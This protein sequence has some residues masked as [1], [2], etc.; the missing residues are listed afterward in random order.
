MHLLV[1]LVAVADGSASPSSLLVCRV[2]Q[3]VDKSIKR[4]SCGFQGSRL[5]PERKYDESAC[6]PNLGALGLARQ[7]TQSELQARIAMSQAMGALE[8]KP[9]SA[10]GGGGGAGRAGGGSGSGL[11]AAT[12][13]EQLLANNTSSHKCGDLGNSSGGAS[14]SSTWGSHAR[15]ARARGGGDNCCTPLLLGLLHGASAPDAAAPVSHGLLGDGGGGAAPGMLLSSHACGGGE[16]GGGGGVL[17]RGIRGVDAGVA[18]VGQLYLPRTH[19]A[20]SAPGVSML[21]EILQVQVRSIVKLSIK[22]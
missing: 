22:N 9:Y 17:A 5:P 12:V 1:A 7:Q 21:Q 3:G 11:S 19:L 20:L 4:F 18:G 2:L 13:L 8:G 15:L 6:L 16:G 14:V 10:L